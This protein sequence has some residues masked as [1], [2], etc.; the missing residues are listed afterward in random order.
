MAKVFL[1]FLISAEQ[2]FDYLAEFTAVE[3]PNAKY[4][5]F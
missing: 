4:K 3:G 1:D 5:H 2:Q